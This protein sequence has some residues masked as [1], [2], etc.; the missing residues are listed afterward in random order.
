M[1]YKHSPQTVAELNTVASASANYP[2]SISFKAR[3]AIEIEARK[4]DPAHASNLLRNPTLIAS[5]ATA[6]IANNV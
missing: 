6:A 3:H 4:I 1:S 2:F 5:A